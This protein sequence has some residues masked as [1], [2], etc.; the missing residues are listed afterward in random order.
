M[1][2]GRKQEY[3]SLLWRYASARTNGSLNPVSPSYGI[4]KAFDSTRRFYCF[5]LIFGSV[6]ILLTGSSISR[7]R[8]TLDLWEDPKQLNVWSCVPCCQSYFLYLI[9]HFDITGVE[10]IHTS[11]LTLLLLLPLSFFLLPTCLTVPLFKMTSHKFTGFIIIV[12]AKR[13]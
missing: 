9:I 4:K 10:S 8:L 13:G 3:C 7:G 1:T 5:L 6:M 2:F 11:F 12:G